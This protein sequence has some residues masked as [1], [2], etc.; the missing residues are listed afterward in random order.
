MKPQKAYF[1]VRVSRKAQKERKEKLESGIYLAP[2]YVFMTRCMQ[3]GEIISIG[4]WA[5]REFPE[6]RVGDT[7][8]M[9]H[10]V[11]GRDSDFL[12]DSDEKYNY[13]L[14]CSLY[15][16]GERPYSYGIYDGEK[17]IPHKEFIFLEAKDPPKERLPMEEMI[18]A[19]TKRAKRGLVLFREWTDSR[20]EIEARMKKLE[21]ENVQLG[22]NLGNRRIDPEKKKDV[23]A[24][25]KS[26]EQE[27]KKMSQQLNRHC[28][29]PYLVAAANPVLDEWFDTRVRPGDIMYCMN[30]M[31]KMVVEFQKKEYIIADKEAIGFYY[32]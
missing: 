32:K 7:L 18:N 13:Y 23:I 31:C 14:C 25:I 6:A 11:E 28:Y 17:I 24:H 10:F 27:I 16:N 20:E 30:F 2:N 21:D 1:L 9:H 15:Y 12:V 22:G 19:A 8:I 29:E 3:Q 5:H 26:N 4:E